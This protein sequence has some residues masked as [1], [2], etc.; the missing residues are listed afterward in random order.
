MTFCQELERTAA[1][2]PEAPILVTSR[3]VGYR[4]MPYRMGSGFEHSVIAELSREAKDLFAKRW[5][6][7]TEPY[8]GTLERAK[9]SEELIQALHSNDRIERLTGNPMLL[10]TLALVKRKVG[11]LPN[12]RSEL[13]SEAVY[14]LLNWN[15]RYP[16]I[17]KEEATT[18]LEYLAFEMCRRGVQ[19]LTNDDVLNLFDQLRKEYP[20][21]RALRRRD[22]ESFLALLE[23]RS[24]ILIRSGGIWDKRKTE[25]NKVW[26]FRHL[27]FQEYLAARALLDGRY[28]E[29]NREIPIARQV[30]GLARPISRAAK[31]AQDKLLK[32]RSHG[33]NRS[34]FLYPTVGTTTLM[35]LSEQSLNHWKPRNPV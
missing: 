16:T 4:D 12:R 33:K 9:R 18:Q 5:I 14:V 1:R 7:V 8:L 11:K 35:E 34:G 30:A 19:R 26:E 17:G 28:P 20:N 15:P 2:Y 23:A 29:R 24:S 3:I 13:Y 25:E 32:F 6:A 22:P 21:I 10:T 31:E 27:T